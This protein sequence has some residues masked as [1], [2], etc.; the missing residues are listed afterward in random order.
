MK[1]TTSLKK[2]L[3]V[4]VGVLA[5]V[6]FMPIITLISAT[7][8]SALAD[9]FSGSEVTNAPPGSG[10]QNVHLYNG[11]NY[12]GDYYAF[13]NCTYWAFMR[14]AQAGEP[15]PNTWGNASTWA[16]NALLQGYKVDH[17]P[18]QYS[19]MQ[20]S[21]V[22][23]GLGHVAFVEKVD[24]DGA[25][26]ISEMNVMGFDEVDDQTMPAAAALNYEFIHGRQM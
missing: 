14:R 16:V 15:I 11:P 22:D 24:P 18:T 26:H 20:I 19:I 17:T 12:P 4:I 23:N 8:I 13:G 3:W 21:N 25:W 6:I 9:A 10:P 2:E 7:N 5:F 1:A